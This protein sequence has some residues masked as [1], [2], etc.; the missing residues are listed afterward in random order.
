M[1]EAMIA[2]CPPS[3]KRRAV[4]LY[5][6]EASNRVRHPVPG[7]ISNRFPG[8][9]QTRCPLSTTRSANHS[10]AGSKRVGGS[11]HI[12][13]DPPPSNPGVA[14]GF[15]CTRNERPSTLFRTSDA[16]NDAYLS[17]ALYQA[18]QDE[19]R[20]DFEVIN[21][22]QLLAFRPVVCSICSVVLQ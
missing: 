7:S 11:S 13:S 21:L 3:V 8:A 22:A 18:L 12:C 5:P 4:F 19:R 17:R 20:P 9:N 2:H 6:G 14:L 15:C 1:A 16:L 10:R